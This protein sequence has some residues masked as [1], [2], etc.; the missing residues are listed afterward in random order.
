MSDIEANDGNAVR[1]EADTPAAQ[2]GELWRVEKSVYGSTSIYCRNE[3]LVF[4]DVGP[5]PEN[6]ISESVDLERL[7][8]EHNAMANIPDPQG[9]VREVR[10]LMERCDWYLEHLNHDEY[11]A[12]RD[13]VRSFVA[14][15]DAL[16]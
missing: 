6:W 15:L 11:Q 5:S 3:M 13:D 10:E 1:R 7:C 14:R 12:L 9:F 4:H 16:K 8:I 2:F